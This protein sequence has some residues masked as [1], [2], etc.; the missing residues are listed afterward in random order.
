MK[1]VGSNETIEITPEHPILAVRTKHCQYKSSRNH[2]KTTIC[3][4]ACVRQK[5]ASYNRECLYKHY[6]NY[7]VEWIKA[8]ELKKQDYV[9]FPFPTEEKKMR[10][11]KLSKLFEKNRIKKEGKWIFL[12]QDRFKVKILDKIKSSKDL[13][14]LIGYYLAEGSI[15]F[16]KK[17]GTVVFS[18]NKNEEECLKDVENIFK[19]TFGINAKRNYS[20]RDNGCQVYVHSKIIAAFFKMFS[21]EKGKKLPDEFILL[22]KKLQK[23]IVK[24]LWYGDGCVKKQ[25]FALSNTSPE[26][27]AQTKLMLLRLGVVPTIYKIPSAGKQGKRKN[28]LYNVEVGGIDLER[29]SKIL[30][31]KHGFTEKRKRKIRQRTQLEKT[32]VLVTSQYINIQSQTPAWDIKK[33][34]N[35]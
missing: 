18:F 17:R 22:P 6:A 30:D 16:N 13:M 11:L 4:K 21:S 14:R 10:V 8:G 24:G 34:V 5:Y 15:K 19:K 31:W 26:L 9:V 28:A 33:Y 2:G 27:V 35:I 29:M 20:K 12:C 7:K 25:K 1:T 3:S 32:F 23:E